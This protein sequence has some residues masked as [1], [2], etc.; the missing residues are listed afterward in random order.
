MANTSLNALTV[1]NKLAIAKGSLNIPLITNI[2][3]DWDG[4]NY[5]S[6]VINVG[7]GTHEAIPLQDVDQLGYS[8]FVN[9]DDGLDEYD[10]YQASRYIEVGTVV[11]A[12][13]KPFIRLLPGE[14]FSGRLSPDATTI[15]AKANGTTLTLQYM[16]LDNN[17]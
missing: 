9:T 12:V 8:Y 17:G 13:F 7:S 1:I 4:N 15:Y 10:T 3:V 11:S 2:K 14:A 5:T 16:I 6:G